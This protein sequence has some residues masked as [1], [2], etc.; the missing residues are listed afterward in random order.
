MK[1]FTS[2]F[3]LIV[4]LLFSVNLYSQVSDVKEKVKEDKENS[5]SGNQRGTSDSNGSSGNVD[6]DLDIGF[7]FDLVSGVF[8]GFAFAHAKSLDYAPDYP[9]RISLEV[10]GAYGVGNNKLV[11]RFITGGSR[12]NWG[13]FG[14]DIRFNRLSDASGTLDLMD[15][16]VLKLRIPIK[17]VHLE[18]GLGYLRVLDENQN[19]FNSTVGFT[20]GPQTTFGFV[21]CPLSMV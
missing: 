1:T 20:W 2:S 21:C 3:F 12:V 6:L 11:N 5:S 16:Q 9:H 4:L 13:I 7:F 15:W 8:R 10:F 17:N 18:Y 14:S 19:Y